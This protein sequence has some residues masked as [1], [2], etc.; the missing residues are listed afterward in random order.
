MR[1]FLV[2]VFAVLFISVQAQYPSGG[3]YGKGG[4]A[5]GSFYGKIVDASTNKS[6]DGASIQ[7]IQFKFD[8]VS[9]KRK[10]VVVS[11]QI[12]QSNGNFVVEN[13]PITA[14]Y[15]LKISL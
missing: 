6:V 4:N 7:M 8:T 15:K 2:L 3:G 11:T 1:Y 13:L 5:M 14:Q 10:E 9:K 12:T